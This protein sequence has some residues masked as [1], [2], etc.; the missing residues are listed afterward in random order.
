MKIFLGFI[1]VGTTIFIIGTNAFVQDLSEKI[2]SASL[3]A[4]GGILSNFIA[5]IY[6]KIH[7]ET[8]KSL[9][10]FHNRFVFTHHLHFGNFLAAKISE[11]TLREKTLS[12]IASALAKNK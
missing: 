4:I 11:K 10:E 3:G 6:L 1:I 5:V 7:S 12:E 9:T 8:I 2:V